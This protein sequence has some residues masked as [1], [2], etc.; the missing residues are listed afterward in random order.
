MTVKMQSGSARGTA[1]LRLAYS[2]PVPDHSTAEELRRY[3]QS[4]TKALPFVKLR[5]HDQ[6]LWRPECYWHVKS[7]QDN[8]RAVR[9]GRKYARAA[10]AAMKVDRN[11]GLIG[12]IVQDIMRAAASRAGTRRRPTLCPI[13]QGF[14]SEIGAAVAQ[15]QN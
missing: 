1:F 15:L 14:L 7:T 13:A 12:L 11:E 9:L 8:E 10:M 6:P 5:A 3:L 4:A 2:A